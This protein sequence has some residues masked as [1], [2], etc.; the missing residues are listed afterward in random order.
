MNDLKEDAKRE[1]GFFR[2][3][4]EISLEEVR[5]PEIERST[6]AIV[7]ITASAICGTDLHLVRDRWTV[8]KLGPS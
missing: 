5:E 8:C 7:R 2:G 6:D 4:G 1:A 3:I